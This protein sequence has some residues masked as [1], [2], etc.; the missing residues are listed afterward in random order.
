MKFIYLKTWNFWWY[1]LRS[2]MSQSSVLP[3]LCQ[4][5]HLKL[6]KQVQDPSRS[7]AWSDFAGSTRNEL[8]QQRPLLSLHRR[9]R[10]LQ[11]GSCGFVLFSALFFTFREN[12]CLGWHW[13]QG[14][15]YS[16]WDSAL[17][18]RRSPHKCFLPNRP[19]GWQQQ[20]T[21]TYS[22]VFAR[23]GT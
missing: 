14:A 7:C 17:V 3:S 22:L 16:D 2:C 4:L 23:V 19:T 18:S 11:C 8:E 9:S 6:A 15:E 21:A 10:L 5:Q 12:F 13:Q 20:N 1:K